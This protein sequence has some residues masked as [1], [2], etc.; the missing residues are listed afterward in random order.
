MAEPTIILEVNAVEATPVWAVIGTAARWVGPDASVGDLTDPFVAPILDADDAFFDNVAAPNDG[1]LWNDTTTDLQILIAGRN[2]N[3]NVLRA[4]ET[5]GTD[6]TADPPEFTAYDD[7]TDAGNRTNPT[8]WLLVGTAGSST[9]SQIRAVETTV[10]AP[11]AGGWVAQI[12]DQDPQ[13]TG[14]GVAAD[15]FALDG[16]KAGEKVVCASVLALSTSKEFNVA[17]CA[18]HDATSG[19]TTFVYAFQYTFE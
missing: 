17:A 5:G 12:H 6:P 13:A 8:A 1:E 16:N 7:A 2:T 3:R 11:S 10:A 9:I 15:G 19:L 18:P 14:T 4:R